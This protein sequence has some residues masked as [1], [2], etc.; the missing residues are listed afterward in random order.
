MK[1][2]MK[3]NTDELKI[4]ITLTKNGGTKATVILNFGD[5]K[6][7]GFRVKDG[8]YG[9]YVDPPVYFSQRNNRW[10]PLI[11]MEKSLWK[12]LEKKI[13]EEYNDQSIPVVEEK[14]S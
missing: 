1:K 10:I 4:Y 11:W 8:K 7:K 6:L 2:F 12:E 14:N 5:F 13:I 3:L 9:L